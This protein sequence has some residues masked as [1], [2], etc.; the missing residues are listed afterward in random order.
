MALTRIADITHK[1]IASSLIAFTVF[2]TLNLISMANYK[3]RRAK[4]AELLFKEEVDLL[5][6]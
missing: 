6:S 2:G 1:V 4:K 3:Y 5:D